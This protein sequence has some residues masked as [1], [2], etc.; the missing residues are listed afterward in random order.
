MSGTLVLVGEGDFDEVVLRSPVPVLVDFFTVWC[1]PC[2]AL[3]PTLEDLSTE[4]GEAVRI[5]SVDAEK[6]PALAQQYDVQGYPTL[7]L[8]RDGAEVARPQVRTRAQLR[9]VLDEARG[10]TPRP[11]SGGRLQP[12]TGEILPAVRHLLDQLDDLA[13]E[14]WER[15]G[16]FVTD[17]VSRPAEEPESP[18]VDE[19]AL[20]AALTR[21]Q[22]DVVEVAAERVGAGA[23]AQGIASAVAAS[24][25]AWVRRS[26]PAPG[27]VGAFRAVPSVRMSPYLP[28]G[29]APSDPTVAAAVCLA[30]LDALTDDVWVQIR[31]VNHDVF[32]WDKSQS[33]GVNAWLCAVILIQAVQSAE[34]LSSDLYEA[35]WEPFGDLID[36]ASVE[37]A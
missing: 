8:V 23:A 15:V 28:A 32:P 30:R 25:D 9:D 13:P 24:F 20:T 11:T 12:D 5:V 22:D 10:V 33:T 37:A 27:W 35:A 7:V 36:R 6:S 21:L 19:E 31:D 4:Y 29:S 1:A 2:K 17:A 26:T 18:E 14:D 16:A 34:L 3:A